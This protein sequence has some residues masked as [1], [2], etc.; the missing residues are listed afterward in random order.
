MDRDVSAG[1]GLVVTAVC[2]K[3][4]LFTIAAV[5]IMAFGVGI[6]GHCGD[7]AAPRTIAELG[8]IVHSS[9]NLITA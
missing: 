1:H 6:A 9:I 8:D 2:I 7:S 4:A 3:D 5:E